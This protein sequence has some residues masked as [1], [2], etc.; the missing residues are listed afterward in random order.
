MKIWMGFWFLVMVMVMFFTVHQD[1]C[2]GHILVFQ[3]PRLEVLVG[4]PALLNC[5]FTLSSSRNILAV[6]WFKKSPSGQQKVYP[7][8]SSAF[9]NRT[10]V[11]RSRF[12][13]SNDASLLVENV[14]LAD[15]GMYF[16]QIWNHGLEMST[17]GNGTLL[18]VTDPLSANETGSSW[19]GCTATALLGSYVMVVQF[20]VLYKCRKSKEGS[21]GRSAPSGAVSR[22]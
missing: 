18:S 21:K 14:T 11:E 13:S 17:T 3:P 22:D 4:Q 10:H 6:S 9:S 5:T 19:L 15:S 1:P 7:V 2:L 16:C 12:R 8:D 20:L